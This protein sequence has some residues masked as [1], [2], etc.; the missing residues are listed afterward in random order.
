MN[1]LYQDFRFVDCLGFGGQESASKPPQAICKTLCNIDD[2]IVLNNKTLQEILNVANAVSSRG[3][4]ISMHQALSQLEYKKI[5]A[6]VSSEKLVPMIEKS[7]SLIEDWILFS[8]DKRTEGGYALEREK[9]E[10]H[11]VK[12][13]AEITVNYILKELDFWVKFL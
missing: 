3:K 9:I 7:P 6:E 13:Q 1:G 11:S 5:R 2:Q 12:E 4:G 10:Q 8:E